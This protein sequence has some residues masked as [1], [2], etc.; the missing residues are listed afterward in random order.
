MKFAIIIL[1]I[2][3]C[4][5]A[6][7][8][9]KF[10]GIFEGI[11][12][13]GL[14]YY[15]II[16]FIIE[17]FPH[18]I[19]YNRY[20]YVLTEGIGEYFTSYICIFVF[21]ATFILSYKSSSSSRKK[22]YSI[23]T[24]LDTDRLKTNLYRMGLFCFYVGGISLIL[25]FVALGGISNALSL[26]ETVRGFQTDLADYMSYTTSLLVIPARLV[27]V[28]P[29]CLWG[30]L[31]FAQGG[32]KQLSIKLY[33]LISFILSLFYYLF[34]AGRA[35][36]VA[37]MLCIFVPILNSKGK[38]HIWKFL[39]LLGCICLPLL[40]IMDALF[41]YLQRGSFGKLD[42][43]YFSYVSQFRAPIN[44]VFYAFDIGNTYGY[45]WGSDFI[46]VFLDFLPG[47]FFEPSYIPTSEFLGGVNWKSTGG[48]PNDIV[49]FSILQFHIF[50]LVL[51][52]F[53]LGH[54]AKRIDGLI[55]SIDNAKAS[56]VFSTVLAVNSFLL[57]G[58]SDFVAIVRAFTLILIPATIMLSCKRKI[59]LNSKKANKH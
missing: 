43:N 2:F 57:V 34:N 31:C 5:I 18:E 35:P 42:F 32:I 54:L 37:F 20:F 7:R 10:V 39:I 36:L 8:K 56:V 29:F 49:T 3:F 59:V 6:R 21:F 50:G 22:V 25:F 30:Y 53:V 51:I 41:V 40:D 23:E 47:I 46:T 52:P 38:R 55:E 26:G 33:I 11:I 17:L 28:A 58:N 12:F 14:L 13:G 27:T 9:K 45:R 24:S 1:F 19:R 15:G 4:L 44:N 48:V 16:P